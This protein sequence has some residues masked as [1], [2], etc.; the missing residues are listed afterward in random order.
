MDVAMAIG[1]NCKHEIVGIRPGE[2]IHEEMITSSDSFYTY[3]LGKYFAILPQTH[4]WLLDD[5]I[6]HFDAVKVKQGFHYNSGENTKWLTVEKI[7]MLIK[8]HVD[9]TFEA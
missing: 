4:T 3:D 9:V 8:K 2:K 7:R 1:P 6:N 5:F